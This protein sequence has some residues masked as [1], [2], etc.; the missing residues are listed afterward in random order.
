VQRAGDLLDRI[1]RSEERRYSVPALRWITTQHRGASAT[2]GSRG[3]PTS[4][5]SRVGDLA[6]EAFPDANLLLLRGRQP[7]L[8]D[9]GFVG[10]AAA[11]VRAHTG[12]LALVVNTHWHFDQVG[13]NA[14]LQLEPQG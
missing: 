11:W 1:V 4:R 10:H 14:L 7:A 3:L 9:R 12:D 5:A 6:A 2:E 13:G 8:V